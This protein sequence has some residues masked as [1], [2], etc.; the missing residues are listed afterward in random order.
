MLDRQGGRKIHVAAVGMDENGKSRI[1]LIFNTHYKGQCQLAPLEKADVV[2]VDSHAKSESELQKLKEFVSQ[3][4]TRP[5]IVLGKSLAVAADEVCIAHPP[6]LNLLWDW[7]LNLTGGDSRNARVGKQNGTLRDLKAIN[8][9][10]SS[11]K[12][13][14]EPGGRS[15]SACIKETELDAVEHES[16]EFFDSEDFLLG[17]LQRTIAE[18]RQRSCSIQLTCWDDRRIIV[19][20]KSGYVLSDLKPAQLKN[21]GLVQVVHSTSIEISD[22]DRDALFKLS[23]CDVSEVWALPIEVLLWNLALRTSRGRLPR[24]TSLAQVYRLSRWPN[25]TRLDQFPDCLRI[26]AYWT[27]GPARLTDIAERLDTEQKYV[28]LFFTAA[29]AVGLIDGVSQ[30]HGPAAVA[31]MASRKRSLFTAILDNLS[32][33]R[34]KSKESL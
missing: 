8:L 32:A 2:L 24:G 11:D 30:E 20:P 18:A 14:P 26:A 13:S 4:L 34:K 22:F 21:L 31:D 6:K 19:Y 25:F 1:S 23:R 29:C 7:I 28:N 10:K 9:G 15:L 3:H 17:K 27:R 12:T 5:Y 33:H 16:G